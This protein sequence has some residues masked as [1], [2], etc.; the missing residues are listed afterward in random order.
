MG[1]EMIKSSTPSA[2]K[3]KLWEAIDII[4]NEDEAAIIKFI[5]KFRKEFKTLDPVNIAFPR[6]VNGLNQV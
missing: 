1:L 6:G 4:F 3:E 2:C 5:D